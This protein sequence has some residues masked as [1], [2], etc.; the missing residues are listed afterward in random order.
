ME[1]KS[2]A[3]KMAE[4]TFYSATFQKSWMIHM[5]AFGPILAPAFED[6]Y[7]AKVHLCAAL[8]FISQ[9]NVKKGFDKL[10]SLQELCETDADKAAWLYF[11][12]LCYE[13]S[14]MQDD[15]IACY[16]QAAEFGHCF[17]LPYL[18]IAKGAH[19]DAVFEV[20]EVNYKFAIQCLEEM[21]LDKQT[22]VILGSAYTNYASC[23]TMMHNYPEAEKMLDESKR[24]LADQPGRAACEAILYAAM[25]EKEKVESALKELESNPIVY[26]TAKEMTDKILSG[27]HAHFSVID[28]DKDCINRFWNWFQTKQETLKGLLQKEDYNEFLK[29]VQSKLKETFSF[30]EREPEI[31]IDVHENGYKLF[32][33]DSYVVSLEHGFRIMLEACPDELTDSWEFEI[34]H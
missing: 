13:M 1:K 18:K 2:F 10:N 24:I 34:T 28:V 25:G 14:G 29:M 23:L 9:K 8:N 7:Q 6:N 11:A 15:M 17:Y 16:T 12:G 30:M 21:E 3:E 31:G 5:Q 19:N 33:A 27:T 22:R 26:K 4:K 20:A 32:L